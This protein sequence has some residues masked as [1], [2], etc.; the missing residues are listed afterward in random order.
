MG[1]PGSVQSFTTKQ[2]GVDYPQASHINQLQTEVEAIE[3]ELITT[4]LTNT[5]NVNAGIKFPATQAASTNANTLDDYEEG[6]W[7]PVL[8]GTGGQSG[9]VYSGQ[10]GKYTK[11]GKMVTVQC[12]VQLSTEG[13]ITGSAQVSGLPF[14]AS[15]SGNVAAACYFEAL[16]TNWISVFAL[17][18][19][20]SQVCLLRGNAAAGTATSTSLAAADISNTTLIIFSL[21]Y[22]ASA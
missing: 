13:T 6:T 5:L 10:I 8:G 11:V 16:A 3:T 14:A 9:Q 17:L 22:E 19:G 4:G 20:G 18:S 12:S 1:Y 7:T 2:D 15:G 21:T